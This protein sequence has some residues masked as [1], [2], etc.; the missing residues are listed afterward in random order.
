MSAKNIYDLQGIEIRFKQDMTLNC[1]DLEV[2]CR[3]ANDARYAM[4][5]NTESL[6][7]KSILYKRTKK[8]MDAYHDMSHAPESYTSEEIQRQRARFCSV[9]Q[10]L[11]EAELVDEYDAWKCAGPFGNEQK[12]AELKGCFAFKPSTVNDLRTAQAKEEKRP[13]RIAATEWLKES[14]FESFQQNLL[15]DYAFILR[16]TI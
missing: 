7:I 2:L 12:P 10:V 4:N 14:E 13:I 11:E 15:M 1:T 16:H 6:R 9:W 3:A 8:E 5:D